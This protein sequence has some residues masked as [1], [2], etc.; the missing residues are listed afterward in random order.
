[1][2]RQVWLWFLCFKYFTSIK[3]FKWQKYYLILVIINPESM[4][5]HSVSGSCW[6]WNWQMIERSRPGTAGLH[7][8]C[9]DGESHWHTYKTSGPSYTASNLGSS[10]K[11]TKENTTG[12]TLLCPA[13]AHTHARTQAR[14]ELR[15]PQSPGHDATRTQSR[16]P[17][18]WN[19]IHH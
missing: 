17:L 15:I 11:K 16:P 14:T 13:H 8:A 7:Q 5:V 10:H 9:A 6:S 18:L 19:R 1:M 12:G 4:S 2:P 3:M